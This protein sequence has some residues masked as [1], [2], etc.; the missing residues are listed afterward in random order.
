MTVMK[1]LPE[2]PLRTVENTDMTAW[3]LEP[4]TLMHVSITLQVE[5]YSII[6]RLFTYNNYTEQ[7]DLVYFSKIVNCATTVRVGVSKLVQCPVPLS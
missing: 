4:H 5:N 2:S 6:Y 1:S 7:V 3:K